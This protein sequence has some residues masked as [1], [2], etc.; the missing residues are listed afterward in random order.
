MG[1]NL[2]AAFNLNRYMN[3]RVSGN[4]FHYS[5]NNIST[6]GFT[7]DGNLNLAA[8]G[9]S[10]DYF[11]FP[12]HGFR[13]SPGLLV[14]NQNGVSASATVAGGTSFT[15]NNVNYD[16][17]T[18]SPVVGTASLDLNS[19]KPAFTITTGWGNMISRRGGHWSFPFEIGAAFVGSPTVNVAFTGGQVCSG[20]DGTG[21]CTNAVGDTSLNINLQAQISKWESDLQP[22]QFYPILSFGVA[23]DFGIR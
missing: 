6:N 22:L 17:S 14:Y 13:V 10:L 18:A 12:N 4:V 7:L 16:S 3:L 9:V 5:V 2:Q 8:V 19:R 21:Q 15:L 23:Y 1:V 11:P 20:P